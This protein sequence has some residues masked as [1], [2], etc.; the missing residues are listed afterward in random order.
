MIQIIS[1]FLCGIPRI[2]QPKTRVNS[3]VFNDR[4]SE[5]CGMSDLHFRQTANPGRMKDRL[6]IPFPGGVAIQ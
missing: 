6:R 5:T 2:R 3:S 4:D 1:P